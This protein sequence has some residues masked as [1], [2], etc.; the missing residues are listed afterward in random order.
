MSWQSIAAKKVASLLGDDDS[1][2]LLPNCLLSLASNWVPTSRVMVPCNTAYSKSRQSA[3]EMG[4]LYF[5]TGCDSGPWLQFIMG[6][7]RREIGRIP[8]P[9]LEGALCHCKPDASST[10]VYLLVWDFTCRRDVPSSYAASLKEIQMPL[11]RPMGSLDK[12]FSLH[13][14]LVQP[15]FH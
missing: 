1:F 4:C 8:R 15:C 12:L 7:D 11:L 5:W 13:P 9:G 6:L 2:S 10:I 3:N 14:S